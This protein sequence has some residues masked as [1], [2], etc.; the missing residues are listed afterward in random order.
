V[1][2][3]A[4]LVS[5]DDGREVFAKTLRGA[6][7]DLFR[8][9]AEGLRALHDLGGARTP[10]VVLVTSNLL[11]LEALRPRD[12][13]A[14][15]WEQA[16]R[17]L[18]TVHTTTVN[19]RFGWEHDGWLGRMRQDNTWT[20][21]GWEF[22]AQRRILRWL[23]EPLAEAAFDA[24]DR[25]NLDRL[26][27]A[28]GDLIPPQPA[29]LTHGDLWLENILADADGRPAF[30]D[31]AVSYSWPEADLSMLWCS[32]RPPVTDRFFEAYAEVAPVQDGWQQRM[33]ILHLRELLSIVA[34]GDDDWGAANAVRDLVRPFAR[35]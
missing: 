23:P 22:F 7:S 17:M 6:D 35:R 15:F 28:L 10:G 24:V 26:C 32:P 4:G 1:I 18:A 29:V 25:E 30:I 19:D 27:A 31:P 13:G 14:R 9:E 33:P 2:A 8:V 16:G 21:D 12:H 3:Q 34:H 5:L 20:D 11:V